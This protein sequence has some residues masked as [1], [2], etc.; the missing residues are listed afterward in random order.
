MKKLTLLSLI[1]LTSLSLS[2]CATSKHKSSATSHS[3]SKVVK[4]HKKKHSKKKSSSSSSSNKPAQQ[5]KQ[6]GQRQ[7]QQNG[8]QTAQSNTGQQRGEDKVGLVI[9]FKDYGDHAGEASYEYHTNGRNEQQA[10][11][12]AAQKADQALD[13]GQTGPINW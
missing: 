5:Q 4:H 13:R 10:A 11:N 12:D 2:A 9:D 8:Q 7:N 1:A 6:N 3:S